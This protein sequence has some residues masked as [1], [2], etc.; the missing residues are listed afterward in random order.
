MTQ[1]TISLLSIN[2]QVTMQSTFEHVHID[3][4]HGREFVHGVTAQCVG[5][6]KGFSLSLSL[7]LSRKPKVF[8]LSLSLS[9]CL[10]LSL[11]CRGVSAAETTKGEIGV[12]GF[13]H[14]QVQVRGFA[15]TTMGEIGNC[16]PCFWSVHLCMCVQVCVGGGDGGDRIVECVRHGL[17]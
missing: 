9:L 4:G 11:I 7:S 13:A 15:E 8:S 12:R 1:L 17:V 5:K 16:A 10:S 14:I 6:T 2:N 3:E